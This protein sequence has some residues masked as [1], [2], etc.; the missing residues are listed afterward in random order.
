MTRH[1]VKRQRNF[2]KFSKLPRNRAIELQRCSNVFAMARPKSIDPS[3]KN[4]RTV[5]LGVR[6][7]ARQLQ[8][9]RNVAKRQGITVTE[10]VRT[11]AVRSFVHLEGKQRKRRAA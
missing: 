3:A 9:L 11:H 7:S 10:L 6:F 4:G 2:E 5:V 8:A 1:G